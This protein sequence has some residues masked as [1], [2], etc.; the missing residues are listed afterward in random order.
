MERKVKERIKKYIRN[1][2]SK[3]SKSLDNI[4][5]DI[6]NDE[7]DTETINVSISENYVKLLD[8]A[9]IAR[10]E[11]IKKLEQIESALLKEN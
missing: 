9:E 3:I 7:E 1:Y 6:M 4:D 10:I 2:L 8:E 5:M 11:F